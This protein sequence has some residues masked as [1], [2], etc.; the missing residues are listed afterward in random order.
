MIRVGMMIMR[1]IITVKV[2]MVMTN[3]NINRGE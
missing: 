2:G 3:T 1:M